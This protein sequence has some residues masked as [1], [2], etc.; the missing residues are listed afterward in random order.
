M[1]GGRTPIGGPEG[2][3]TPDLLAA[4]QALYQLSYGPRREP[5]LTGGGRVSVLPGEPL[6]VLPQSLEVVVA[7]LLLAED[8]HDDVD[9][10]EEHPAALRHSFAAERLHAE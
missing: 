1:R 9:V 4:S 10:V 6:G 3:R 2:N 7:A 5:S 8:V